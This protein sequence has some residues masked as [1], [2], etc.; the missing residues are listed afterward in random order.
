M[1]SEKY[2]PVLGTCDFDIAWDSSTHT[3]KAAIKEFVQAAGAKYKTLDI[4]VLD[5]EGPSG[6]PLVKFTGP[7]EDLDRLIEFYDAA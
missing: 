6:W 5:D 2:F 7:Q 1:D 4:E 3:L